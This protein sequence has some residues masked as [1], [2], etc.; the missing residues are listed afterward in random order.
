MLTMII[1]GMARDIGREGSEA[2]VTLLVLAMEELFPIHCRY[3]L[4][5]GPLQ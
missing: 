1:G 5:L 2:N 3:R 4:L